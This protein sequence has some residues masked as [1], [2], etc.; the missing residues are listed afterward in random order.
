MKIGI[1]GGSFDP[2]HLGHLYLAEQMYQQL[3]LDRVLFVPSGDPYHKHKPTA[4][5]IQ[6]CSMV[7]KAIADNPHFKINFVDVRRNGPTYSVDTVKDLRKLYGKEARFFFLI[8]ADNVKKIRT[9]KNYKTFLNLVK[10]VAIY[11]PA[12]PCRK[13][14]INGHSIKIQKYLALNISSKQV[15]QE[16]KTGM[17]AVRYKLP[18]RVWRYIYR[19]S[20]YL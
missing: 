1:L 6:R 14:N 15:R 9:W 8:G 19:R 4:T 20:L 13:H 7:A 16:L 5:R 17:S 3:G 12:E 10:V 2:I 11:R 18:P